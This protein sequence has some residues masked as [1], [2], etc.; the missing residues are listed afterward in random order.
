MRTTENP[1][2]SRRQS[3][4]GEGPLQWGP[5]EPGQGGN[6]AAISLRFFVWGPLVD[7]RLGQHSARRSLTGRANCTDQG[8]IV[9][10]P[11]MP[12]SSPTSASPDNG[13]EYVVVAR[14]YRPQTFDELI[15]QEHVAQA[16]QGGH[17]QRPRRPRLSVHR[18]P[19]RRQ[20]LARPASSPS[21]STASGARRRRPA[22][23]A[24]SARASPPA[25]TSTS[26]D[27][28]RQ[29][30]RHR[31]DPPASAERRRAAEPCAVQDLHH[32]R[33]PH[34]HEGGVQ[35]AAQDAGRAARACEVHLRH[36]RGEQDPDHDPVALPA[37]RLRGHRRGGDS[38]AAAPRSRRPRESRP[39][40]MR[41]RFIAMRAA[42]SMRDSQS[43]LEQLLSTG[44]RSESRPPT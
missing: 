32:R 42:G 19:R 15:G 9:L 35:R 7:G 8:S 6:T 37:V 18:R 24:T 5:C 38:P 4:V 3:A 2:V 25:T 40:P 29:Q 20:D 31:R 21:A 16:L 41:W 12:D 17:R 28:R 11:P 44:S 14:R 27:R 34:A 43:L 22:T 13:G 10:R 39:R 23:S 1:V 36:D 30:P 26:R 33:S